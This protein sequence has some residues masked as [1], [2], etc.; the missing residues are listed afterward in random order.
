[1]TINGGT[2]KSGSDANGAPN[3]VIYARGKG[4]VYVN[5]GKF[6]NDDKSKFVLNKK[7]ADRATTIIEVRGGQFWNFNPASN[8]AETSGTN[9]CAQGY[10]AAKQGDGSW[11]VVPSEK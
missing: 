5:G 3:A 10:E 1:L 9:F 2:F 8:A 7:D 11:K 6:P 4:E